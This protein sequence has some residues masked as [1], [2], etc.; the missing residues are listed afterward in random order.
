MSTAAVA[1]SQALKSKSGDRTPEQF[2]LEVPVNKKF[3]LSVPP[4]MQPGG[5]WGGVETRS[6]GGR[7]SD[8]EI[9]DHDPRIR[10]FER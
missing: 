10:Y 9:F 4:W 6:Y 2:L 8:K 1:L 5:G 3:K 7:N